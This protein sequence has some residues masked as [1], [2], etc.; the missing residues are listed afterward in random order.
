MNGSEFVERLL[1]GLAK[2]GIVVV[3]SRDRYVLAPLFHVGALLPLWLGQINGV[4]YLYGKSIRPAV[5]WSGLIV[6]VTPCLWGCVQWYRHPFGS[7]KPREPPIFQK[8]LFA[9]PYRKGGF[10]P[11]L[12]RLTDDGHLGGRGSMLTSVF[13]LR[14][15][16]KPFSNSSLHIRLKCWLRTTISLFI[17]P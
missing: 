15:A 12:T 1:F 14:G 2:L 13:G 16:L 11:A 7:F 8:I 5:T 6:Q 10:S 4:V 17:I 9:P 3:R